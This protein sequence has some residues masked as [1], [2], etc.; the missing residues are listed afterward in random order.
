MIATSRSPRMDPNG[1]Q[2]YAAGYAGH[3]GK[4]VGLRGNPNK[5]LMN[6][7]TKDGRKYTTSLVRPSVIKE[8]QHRIT[9]E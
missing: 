4:L 5:E 6:N 1:F 2:G 7:K 8:I 9:V 3:H